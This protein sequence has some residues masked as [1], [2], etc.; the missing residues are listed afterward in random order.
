MNQALV[1]SQSSLGEI[2]PGTEDTFKPFLVTRILRSDLLTFALLAL[3][4]MCLEVSLQFLLS[5]ECPVT[6]DTEVMSL[7]DLSPVAAPGRGT[8]EGRLAGGAGEG[9]VQLGSSSS[10]SST[11]SSSSFTGDHRGP[12]ITVPGQ[13]DLA[14]LLLVGS[15]GV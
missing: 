10:S 8:G 11:S 12:E 14:H 1:M 7:V 3:R 6:G 9:L 15:L 4:P 2:F 5:G 13:G